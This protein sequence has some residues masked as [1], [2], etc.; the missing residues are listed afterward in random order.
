MAYSMQANAFAVK[1]SIRGKL[2]SSSKIYP[3][4]AIIRSTTRSH[5]GTFVTKRVASHGARTRS[6]QDGVRCMAEGNGASVPKPRPDYI[7]NRIDD[8][9]Y[10]RIFD[11]TLRD[12]EQSP[13][14]TLTSK[15]KLDIARQLH[16]LGVD[17]IEAG[18]P[19]ASPDDLEAVRNIAKTVGNDVDESRNGY[20]PVICG[21]SRANKGD[22]DAA[23]EAVRHARRPR[24]HT[25]I[26]TSS[27]HMQF[28]LNKTPDE[29][30]KLAVD[31]VKYCRSL[32]CE[33]V[34]FSPEDAG[35]SDPEFLYRILGEV[36]KAGATTL[37]IP[38][39]V[40]ITIPSEFG[41][42]IAKI[43]ANTP[44]AENVIISTHCQND[45]GLATG[46]TLAGAVNG[47]R[48]LECTI[49]GIG[50]RAGNASLE[51]VALALE[52]RG[53][54]LMGGL[55]T[56]LD[57]KHIALTS[58]MVTEYTGMAVQPHKA[59]VG[60][61]AF[62]HESGIHQDGM[63]KNKSTY[64]IIEPEKVGIVRKDAAGIVMG[65]H[66]GRHALRT[67]MSQLGVELEGAEL[68]EVFNRFK[69]VAEQKTGGVSDDDL[70]AILS[71]ELYQP[72]EIWKL[73]DLQVVAGTSG[74]PTATV[75]LQGPDGMPKIHCSVGTGPVDAAYKAVDMALQMP[76]VLTE[77]S[78]Q[79]V[80][81]GIDALAVTKVTVKATQSG[82]MYDRAFSGSGADTDIVVSSVRAYI[83]ALNKMI[84]HVSKRQGVENSLGTMEFDEQKV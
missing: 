74:T 42:L 51:E 38:D 54:N 26:A 84:D 3:C 45:L 18:F 81:G 36:I 11:T 25:F 31:A 65:K 2:K 76:A 73:L 13:G 41:E 6:V 57:I 21:L 19:C 70:M 14:A 24:I 29:V 53:A 37:N 9:N 10:V 52:L 43:K 27:I 69:L 23:W 40:G 68:A 48:Q 66:S 63:L 16:K 34:E 35:R 60:A 17:I 55:R 8:P 28:K 78:M 64:E 20:V 12:G 7:P 39:T 83:N 79:A 47:A 46:N 5:V 49:N 33:D 80:N 44:G 58:R 71:D 15:E 67:R 22:I 75:R 77:Y 4:S 82:L 1:A 56:G 32:G 30:V 61:N 50:E 72:V 62:A 59:I